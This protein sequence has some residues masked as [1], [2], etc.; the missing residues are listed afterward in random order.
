MPRTIEV[1]AKQYEDYDDC[2]K[3]AADDFAATHSC[4]GWDLEPRWTDD[5]RNTIALTVPSDV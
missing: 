2:L 3:A 4:Q 5:E 1:D